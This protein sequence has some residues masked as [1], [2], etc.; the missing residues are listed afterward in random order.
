[1]VRRPETD[2]IAGSEDEAR[3][4]AANA[5]LLAGDVLVEGAKVDERIG[6]ERVRLGLPGVEARVR[7][8]GSLSRLED[9]P[10]AE[11]CLGEDETVDRPVVLVRALEAETDRMLTPLELERTDVNPSDEARVG[12]AVGRD[13]ELADG[14]GDVDRLPTAAIET[15]GEARAGDGIRAQPEIIGSSLWSLERVVSLRPLPLREMRKPVAAR[16]RVLRDA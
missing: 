6:R 2:A 1:G 8:S 12:L 16:E 13:V 10:R 3:A 9:A 15:V 7:E 4:V 11:G 14:A 5:P